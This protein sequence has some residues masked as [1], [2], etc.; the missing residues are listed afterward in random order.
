MFISISISTTVLCSDQKTTVY[1]KV[2]HFPVSFRINLYFIGFSLCLQES[3]GQAASGAGRL[4]GEAQELGT[5]LQ[6]QEPGSK[7][8]VYRFKN[9]VP[10]FSAS[11]AR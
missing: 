4:V 1:I 6:L 7:L 3:R 8:L 10:F 5:L 9:S 11:G 2:K